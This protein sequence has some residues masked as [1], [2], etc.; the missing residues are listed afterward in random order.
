[1]RKRRNNSR[2]T[3]WYPESVVNGDQSMPTSSV[4]PG[5]NNTQCECIPSGFRALGTAIQPVAANVPLRVL[6][7]G[8]EFDLNNEY[9]I[10][11]T[12][13]PNQRGMYS[14]TA[15]VAFNPNNLNV[16]SS[17]T[18][19]ILVNNVLRATDNES[20]V[21]GIGTSNLAVTTIVELQAGDRVEVFFQSSNAGRIFP[22]SPFASMATHFEAGRLPS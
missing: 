10:P 16:T 11:A 6:Y 7:P 3:P 14:I 18:L 4:G 15:S 2:S 5:G 22:S 8:V 17:L 21:P 1:M 9:Q 19:Q 20:F 13:V 12:F